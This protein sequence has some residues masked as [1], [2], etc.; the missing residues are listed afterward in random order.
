MPPSPDD[1]ERAKQHFFAGVA[2]FETH[3]YATAETQFRAALAIVPDR[4]SALVNLA[5]VL[6]RQ[7][8]LTEAVEVAQQ[9]L[10]VDPNSWDA[11]LA[12]GSALAELG[13]SPSAV[14]AMDRA[15]SIAPTE[16][17]ALMARA[18]VYLR[19]RRYDLAIADCEAVRHIDPDRDKLLGLLVLAKTSICDWRNLHQ[20]VEAMLHAIRAGTAL[21]QPFALLST[22]ST[23]SDQLACAA[24]VVKREYPPAASSLYKGERYEHDRIRVAYVSGDYR[25]HPLARLMA[26]ILERHDRSRFAITAVSTAPDDGSQERR[27]IA[28]APEH[29]VDLGERSSGEIAA[30]LRSHEIDIAVDLGG[31][32]DGGRLP[33]FATRPAP[34]QVSYLGFPATSG[35]PYLDYLIADRYVIPAAQRQYYSEKIAALPDTYYPTDDSWPVASAAPA[36][37]EAGLPEQGFVFCCFNNSY[38]ITPAVFDVWM[39]LLKAVPGSVFWLLAANATATANLAK[40]AKQRGIEPERL[41][42]AGRADFGRHLARQR[43]ADLFLDTLP[44]NAHTTA[45]DALW[46]GLPVVTCPGTTFPS[47][48]AASLLHA[49]HLPELVTSSLAD[50]EALAL[51]LAN[52]PERLAAL[53]AKVAANRTTTRLFDTAQRTRDLEA[54]YT[55]MVAR[56]RSGEAP[57]DFVVANAIR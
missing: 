45:C 35:A 43:L 20:D 51:A 19:L 1:T 18:A 49:M 31:F 32:T 37:A 36:R 17:L 21:D 3:D 44:Y 28:A 10:A 14:A 56:H 41:V 42:F 7:E 29:F 46:A 26:G 4:V 15:V 38:K 6:L 53:K 13:D 54:A 12:M 47:R 22:W 5:V 27:R 57:A 30:W 33:V 40:E 39:R 11:L 8:M 23:P 16:P 24:A 50:Y 2:A 9:A 25:D 48:V 55:T 52:D 34:V